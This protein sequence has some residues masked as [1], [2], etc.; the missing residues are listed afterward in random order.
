M[1]S[2]KGDAT[3]PIRRSF[4]K[5]CSDHQRSGLFLSTTLDAGRLTLVDCI[6]VGSDHPL[7]SAAYMS[8][9][10]LKKGPAWFL[11][12]T[13]NAGRLT[14]ADLAASAA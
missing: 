12:T 6:S 9:A 2:S 11:S 3:A 14:L 4:I 5:V 10:S 7:G 13:L 8:E 1:G